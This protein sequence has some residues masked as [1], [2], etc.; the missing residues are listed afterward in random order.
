M[1]EFIITHETDTYN[2]TTILSQCS[3]FFSDHIHFCD[4]I[5]AVIR[6]AL[7]ALV[8]VAAVAVLV[9]DIRSRKAKQDTK[10][11]TSPSDYVNILEQNCEIKM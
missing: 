10:D 2:R 11:Q 8:G 7:A 6:L 4:S 3:S 1:P 9:Y 5:E